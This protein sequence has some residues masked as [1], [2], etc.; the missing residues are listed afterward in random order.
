MSI[1]G[2]AAT[3]RR[4]DRRSSPASFTQHRDSNTAAF[5]PAVRGSGCCPGGGSTT[6]VIF[7]TAHDDPETRKQALAAGC[8]GYFRKTDSGG[9]VL[10][11]IRRA[12]ASAHTATAITGL[13]QSK[14]ERPG[15]LEHT[16]GKQQW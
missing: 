9:E 16:K 15:P 3:L 10:D 4:G 12:I 8:A 11:A 2:A 5:R 6:P 1:R 14:S 13:T 7:I